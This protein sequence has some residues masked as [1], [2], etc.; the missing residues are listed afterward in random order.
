[1]LPASVEYLHLREGPGAVFEIDLPDKR[2]PNLHTLIFN[3]CR[4]LC[5]A[6]LAT[7]LFIA[8]PPLRILRVEECFNIHMEDLRPVLK[9][10]L[11]HNQQISKITEL[12]LVH[13]SG[14]DDEVARELFTMFPELKVL[15][16]TRTEIT[17][18]T[19]RMFA[20]ARASGSDE[21]ANLDFLIVRCCD[22][23]S[24]DAVAYGRERGLEVIT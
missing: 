5:T 16:L 7:F 18:I 8:E 10:E 14:V 19:I 6:V 9:D 17:G 20:D 12:G 24:S 11:P 15:D 23:I 2:L 21:G 22:D 3:D 4:W 1:M 13:V